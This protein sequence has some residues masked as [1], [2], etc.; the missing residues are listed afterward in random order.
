MT[1]LSNRYSRVVARIEAA[2]R[3]AGR[4]GQDVRLIAV[5]KGR[6]LADVLAL[7]ELGQRH[8][9]ENRVEEGGDKISAARQ[10]HKSAVWHMIGHVQRRKARAV[11]A[12]FDW[13]HSLDGAPL[14]ERLGRSAVEAGRTLPVLLECNVSGEVSKGGLPAG[15]VEED[16]AEWA[17]LCEAVEYILAAPGLQVQGLMTMAPIVPAPDLARP[18]FRRLRQLRDRLADRFPAGSWTELSMGMTDDFEVAIEEGATL[19]RIGR[20]IFAPEAEA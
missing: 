15:R 20:A 19:V 3:K 10:E 16:P 12:D 8:F 14:A 2:A 4:A 6:A 18:V 9:G 11:A 13:V 17:A 5:S 1:N 7:Y